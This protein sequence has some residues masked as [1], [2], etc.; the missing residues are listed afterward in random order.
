[1]PMSP[2][3]RK[4]AL[5]AHV[6]CT[7]GWLGALAAFLALAV[8]GLNS[9]DARLVQACY[10]AMGLTTWFVIVPLSLA[11]LGTGLVQALGTPWGLF[12]HYWVLAKLVLTIIAV[13]VLL[14]KVPPISHLSAVASESGLSS[15]DLRGLRIS[16]MIHA[17]GGMLVLIATTTLALYKPQGVIERSASVPRWVKGFAVVL[18]TLIVV[19]AHMIFTGQHGPGAHP[20]S[21]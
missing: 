1:M 18:L 17:V 6:T 21:P 14:L 20:L 19:V 13:T 16:V 3:V 4:L 11:S 8:A 9:Q 5:T 12:R 10:V 15:S 7:V 2:Q